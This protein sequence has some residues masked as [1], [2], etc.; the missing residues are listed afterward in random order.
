[1]VERTAAASSRIAF[2]LTRVPDLP[3]WVDTRG[4]LLSGRADVHAAADADGGFVTCDNSADPVWG[5]LETNT[6]SRRW[7]RGSSLSRRGV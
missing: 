4:M 5:A 2:A 6:A 1:M 7:P 3:R